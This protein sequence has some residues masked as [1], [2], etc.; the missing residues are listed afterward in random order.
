MGKRFGKIIVDN[1]VIFI[2]DSDN[3][4]DGGN[5]G[6]SCSVG[7]DGEKDEWSGEKVRRGV[8]ENEVNEAFEVIRK[9]LDDV[10]SGRV[11]FGYVDKL[12]YAIWVIVGDEYKDRYVGIVREWVEKLK[13]RRR[14]Y[15]EKVFKG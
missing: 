11:M 10:G 13:E 1:D 14:K 2:G 7:G 6:S 15:A 3:V 5:C 9:F 8:K 12:V 4:G